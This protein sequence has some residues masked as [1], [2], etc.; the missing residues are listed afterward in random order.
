METLKRHGYFLQN[1]QANP[2][3]I[4]METL[5]FQSVVK[6]FATDLDE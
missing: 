3:D 1:H 5:L 6:K 2:M 4:G